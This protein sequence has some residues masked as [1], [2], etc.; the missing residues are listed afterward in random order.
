MKKLLAVV[1]ALMLC[2][3]TL[4]LVACGNDIA[5]T[6]KFQSCSLSFQGQEVNI[7]V[8][9][10]LDTVAQGF[11]KMMGI[12]EVTAD[13]MIIEVKSDKTFTM[14]SALDEEEVSGTWK[15]DGDKYT[16]TVDGEDMSAEI[17]GNKLVFIENIA[18]Q[19]VSFTLVK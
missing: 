11:V 2:V 6:Y 7:E 16:F 9:K 17:D 12:E 10:E 8:G 1:I 5:G 3:A 18:G 4:S 19:G 13:F 14:T 15:A